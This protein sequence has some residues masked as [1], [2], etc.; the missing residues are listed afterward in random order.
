M[1]REFATYRGT[2]ECK[3]KNFN[4]KRKCVQI[5]FKYVIIIWRTDHHVSR[6]CEARGRKVRQ[7]CRRRDCITSICV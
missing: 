5:F 6:E 3:D 7:T 4:V 1:R 2:S